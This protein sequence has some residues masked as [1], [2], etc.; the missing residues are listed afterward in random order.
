MHGIKFLPGYRARGRCKRERDEIAFE[1][2]VDEDGKGLPI[3]RCSTAVSDS[4]PVTAQVRTPASAMLQFFSSLGT[5][6]GHH[7]SALRFFWIQQ[8]ACEASH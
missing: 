5:S 1:L 3:F 6:V 2:K 4:Q 7:M 8:T